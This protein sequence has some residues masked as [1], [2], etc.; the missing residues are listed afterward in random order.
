MMGYDGKASVWDTDALGTVGSL[1]LDE[2]NYHHLLLW[3]RSGAWVLEHI[4]QRLEFDLASSD[5]TADWNGDKKKRSTF[6]RK[7]DNKDVSK[8]DI[9]S[10]R[11]RMRGGTGYQAIARYNRKTWDLMQIELPHAGRVQCVSMCYY[12]NFYLNPRKG[13][14][15]KASLSPSPIKAAKEKMDGSE[16]GEYDASSIKKGLYK[17]RLPTQVFWDSSGVITAMSNVT[18]V[19]YANTTL[20]PK[21]TF[22]RKAPIFPSNSVEWDPKVSS[23][24][25]VY[26]DEQK[27]LLVKAKI[28]G[29]DID[30]YWIL[31]TCSSALCISEK[32]AKSLD[33]SRFGR[34]E[35]MEPNGVYRT[36]LVRCNSLQIGPC[37]LKKAV[38]L[39]VE[40][41]VAFSFE[42]EVVGIVGYDFWRRAVVEIPGNIHMKPGRTDFIQV[43]H[44]LYF[45]NADD[46]MHV[47]ADD[48]NLRPEESDCSD[49]KLSKDGRNSGGKNL[50]NPFTRMRGAIWHPNFRNNT[51]TPIELVVSRNMTEEEKFAW[52]MTEEKVVAET[53]MTRLDWWNKIRQWEKE[54]PLNENLTAELRQFAPP[55]L[56]ELP[57]DPDDIDSDTYRKMDTWNKCMPE[58][59]YP[60]I[61]IDG[62]EEEEEA[63]GL[64]GSNSLGLIDMKLE[65]DKANKSAR[66]VFKDFLGV[67]RMN[68]GGDFQGA[69]SHKGVTGGGFALEPR[70]IAEWHRLRMY[71]K[72]PVIDAV[73]KTDSGK[74]SSTRFMIDN[75]ASG[76]PII[77]HPRGARELKTGSD[78]LPGVMGISSVQGSGSPLTFHKA[79]VPRVVLGGRI[80]RNVT[81]L[82]LGSTHFDVG[83]SVSG[84][85]TQA[86]LQPFH[87]IWD[88]PRRRLM[89]KAASDA[90]AT[91][92]EFDHPDLHLKMKFSDGTPLAPTTAFG[93]VP[94]SCYY[95]LD[96]DAPIPNSL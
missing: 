45:S 57:A 17:I 15:A 95:D 6:K 18:S 19:R 29:K 67:G 66:L 9:V 62:M 48:I 24:V 82:Q 31:D 81:A 74:L 27:H 83:I 8:K 87:Q 65:V 58:A 64:H 89:L 92:V 21:S 75:G 91:N 55:R 26:Q 44:P 86:F 4:A 23:A 53:N 94:P 61:E 73:V 14:G 32:L 79:T 36:Q 20:Y 37:R 70:R 54:H 52:H 49:S 30:G 68:Q 41:F 5:D 33:L 11:F 43:R 16:S 63:N 2:E 69:L 88:I 59:L 35:A 96:D 1:E 40:N 13:G 51:L 71:S 90:H 22:S 28:N 38:M 12:K 84:F 3:I 46:D 47:S 85:I 76:A 77:L 42:K 39:E 60:R 72:V 80:F 34:T 50:A 93:D 10:I 56:S 7:G 78:L 25:P